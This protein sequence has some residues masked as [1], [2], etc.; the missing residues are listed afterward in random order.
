MIFCYKVPSNCL[1]NK[2]A[3]DLEN[4]LLN[5][6]TIDVSSIKLKFQIYNNFVNQ[7]TDEFRIGYNSHEHFRVEEVNVIHQN[8][9]PP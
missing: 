7:I 2:S 5:K 9:L 3:V 4:L 8:E 6:S 1:K